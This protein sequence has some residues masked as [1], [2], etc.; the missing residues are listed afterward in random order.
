MWKFSTLK[1]LNFRVLNLYTLYLQD[2]NWG[3][4]FAP[5]RVSGSISISEPSSI[6]SLPRGYTEKNLL[7]N[8]RAQKCYIISTF[9]I[10]LA[11][12]YSGV[13]NEDSSEYSYLPMWGKNCHLAFFQKRPEI[14]TDLFIWVRGETIFHLVIFWHY[15]YGRYLRWPKA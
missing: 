14:L 10:G 5:S 9:L 6:C 11:G 15:F 2:S 4:L 12:L 1:L 3:N 13:K 7:F 8:I